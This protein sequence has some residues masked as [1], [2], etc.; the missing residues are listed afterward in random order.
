MDT[1]P[2]FASSEDRLNEQ[3]AEFLVLNKTFV[4]LNKTFLIPIGKT[5]FVA[6]RHFAFQDDSFC[7]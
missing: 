4:K 2:R 3:I 1:D 7:A 5:L 6:I